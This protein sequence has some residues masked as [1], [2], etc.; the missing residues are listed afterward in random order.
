MHLELSIERLTPSPTPRGPVAN[1]VTIVLSGRNNIQ[2]TYDESVGS[3][4]R[5]GDSA[6]TLGSRLWHVIGPHKLERTYRHSNNIDSIVVEVQGDRCT[7]VW[8]STLLP[9]FDVYTFP[10]MATHQVE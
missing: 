3:L 7:A 5:H 8:K 2:E 6:Q 1:D 10:S 4:S 9:G